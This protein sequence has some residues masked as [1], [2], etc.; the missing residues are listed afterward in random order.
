NDSV[1]NSNNSS[2]NVSNTSTQ[3]NSGFRTQN[4]NKLN[5]N[6]NSQQEA[7]QPPSPYHKRASVDDIVGGAVG[8]GGGSLGDH[9]NLPKSRIAA[10]RDGG[11]T[12]C[13]PTNASQHADHKSI[14]SCKGMKD[15]RSKKGWRVNSEACN[16]VLINSYNG[17]VKRINQINTNLLP[18]RRN[19]RVII[20]SGG[21]IVK[22][23]MG[24]SFPI[25]LA[26]KQRSFSHFYNLQCQYPPPMRPIY[27]WNYFDSNTF[28]ARR[29]QRYI[30]GDL[31]EKLH[32]RLK[33]DASREFIYTA[34]E[35]IYEQHGLPGD[36]CLMQAICEVS[37]LPFHVPRIWQNHLVH[38]WQALIN[39]I[40][41]PTVP[42]VAMR[43][44]H[45]SQAGR[46]GV[47][48]QQ[49]FSECPQRVNGWLRNVAHME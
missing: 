45:A 33:H 2:N 6:P 29:Q 35:Q 41:I 37:Q 27:W 25:I 4:C 46:F 30:D 22:L 11:T 10:G 16:S 1:Y 44:L 32:Q 17:R 43:Y 5:E 47:D 49:T 26:D 13:A 42:N 21:G 3:P 31:K 39:A 24:V 14:G 23:V 19:K 34:I 20:F 48:C 7:P 12:N 28:A 15:N 38:L 18:Q 36:S 9:N 40:L 8:G